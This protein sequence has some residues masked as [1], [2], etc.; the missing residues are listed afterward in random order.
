MLE[1]NKKLSYTTLDELYKSGSSHTMIVQ[2]ED[3]K[4]KFMGF[5]NLIH[6]NMLMH[7]TLHPGKIIFFENN[8]RNNITHHEVIPKDMYCQKILFDIDMKNGSKELFQ[9]VLDDL[10]SS[11]ISI[12]KTNR[13]KPPLDLA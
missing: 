13:I 6:Y 3:S 7:K 12:F 2:I 1:D 11:L 5:R 10:I 8:I 9:N 4:R